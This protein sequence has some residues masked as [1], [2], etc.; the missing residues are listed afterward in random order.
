MIEL[1]YGEDAYEM[2]NSYYSSSLDNALA[3]QEST[4]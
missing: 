3:I 1:I 4:Q 2:L